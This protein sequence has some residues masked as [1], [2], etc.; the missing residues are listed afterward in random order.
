MKQGLDQLDLA[1]VE[2]LE[3]NGRRS[4]RSISRTLGVSEGTVR[5]RI[6]RLQS[7]GLLRIIAVRNLSRGPFALAHLGIL[8]QPAELQAA[9]DTIAAM[10]E[11]VFTAIAI[12]HYDIVA[13]CLAEG[14]GALAAVVHDRIANIPGVR[15]VES[16]ETLH[17][18]KFVP[19]LR[20][21][22]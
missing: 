3:R 4:N 15:R 6:K 19:N 17:S 10:P 11:V 8:V 16:T 1:I 12:G 14:R 2:L 21:I 13:M 20:K 7:E 18:V 5:T 9:A 22:R